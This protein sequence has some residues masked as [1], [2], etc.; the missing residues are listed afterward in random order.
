M[1]DSS[2]DLTSRLLRRLAGGER[3]V[4]GRLFELVYEDLR[5]RAHGMMIRQPANHT[6]QTTALVHEAWLKLGEPKDGDL[7]TRTHYLRLA[8]RAMRSVL[9]DHARARATEKRGGA[10]ARLPLDEAGVSI[11]GPSQT[12]L[13]L[14][15]SL[16]R[17]AK[18][19][20]DL[21]RI[22][23]LRLFGGLEHEEVARALGVSTKTVE[24]AW[25]L[26]RAWLQRDLG[27]APGPESR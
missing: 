4:E 19:D 10:A 26:A 3:D 1:P 22:A 11:D 27:R 13:E 18:A 5:K 2:R 17:L 21:A 9:V 14:D 8:S 7:A 25:K 12:L 15:E 24:R 16:T 23:E 6:L 20:R